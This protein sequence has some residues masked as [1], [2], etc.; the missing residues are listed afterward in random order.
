MSTRHPVIAITGSS[1]AGTTT[2]TRTFEHIFRREGITAAIV[3]GDSFHRYDRTEMKARMAEASANGNQHFSHFGPEAN[4]L[5]D[6]EALFRAYGESGTGKARKYLHNAQEA[7]PY[8][9]EP[10]TFTPWED[11]PAGTDLLF[12]EGL[13]GGAVTDKVNIAALADLLIGVVPIINLEWIQKLHRDQNL[14]GYSQD[15]VV[16]T[17]LR[18]MPDYVNYI[19]PQFSQTHVNFQRVPMVDTSNP[20]IARDIPTVDESMVVIRFARPQGIDFLYLLS[21]LHDSYM[22]RPNIIVVPGG[23]MSLA[24][25][26]ILTPMILQLMDRQRRAG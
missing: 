22:S 10:G 19:C 11:V 5:E 6:L 2:V 15:A 17:I 24:M 13:H 23:K 1:G 3:E 4:R 9:Q 18:R 26:L 20:F 25:Q 21:M 7:A 14:R 16:D 8:G 12:Y